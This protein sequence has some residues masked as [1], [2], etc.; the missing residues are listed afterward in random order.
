MKNDTRGQVLPKFDLGSV[1]VVSCRKSQIILSL[2]LRCV[3][4]PRSIMLLIVCRLLWTIDIDV[5]IFR[6]PV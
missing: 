4:H 2:K 1:M 6:F 5:M 3:S